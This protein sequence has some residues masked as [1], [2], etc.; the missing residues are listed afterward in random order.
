MN[1][2]RFIDKKV[3]RQIYAAV[4]M[5]VAKN[6]IFYETSGIRNVIL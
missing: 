5:V 6:F 4:G 1:F 3:I 2:A